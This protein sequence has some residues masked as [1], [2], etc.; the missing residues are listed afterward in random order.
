M[1]QRLPRKRVRLPHVYHNI[2]QRLPTSSS[3]FCKLQNKPSPSVLCEWVTAFSRPSKRGRLM[4]A[5]RTKHHPWVHR[6][7]PIS[8]RNVFL[9]VCLCGLF[10]GSASVSFY[11]LLPERQGWTQYRRRNLFLTISRLPPF[12]FYNVESYGNLNSKKNRNKLWG[13]KALVNFVKGARGE[14]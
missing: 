9:W 2:Y 3:I 13:R 7:R 8:K 11:R 1:A 12:P 5:L 14:E 10:F 4:M 6:V